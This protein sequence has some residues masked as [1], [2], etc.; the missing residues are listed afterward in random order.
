MG[1]MKIRIVVMFLFLC[2][3][4][5]N[6]QNYNY[7]YFAKTDIPILHLDKVEKYRDSTLL[8]CTYSADAGFW[9]NISSNTY[10]EDVQTKRKYKIRKCIGFPFSPDKRFFEN[11][12]AYPVIMYFPS[13][14]DTYQ[15]NVIDSSENNGINIYGIDLNNAPFPRSYNADEL[16][17]FIRQQEFY[18]QSGNIKKAI[19][20]SQLSLQAKKFIFGN[21]SSD[22]GKTLYILSSLQFQD[23]DIKKA[24]EYG[25]EGLKID[26]ENNA[27]DEILLD[28][29][30]NLS[31]YYKS[32]N[33]Y[34]KAI[35]LLV[36]SQ[37]IFSKGDTIKEEYGA[38]L[39]ELAHCNN[40]IGNYDKALNYAKQSLK[41]KKMVAGEDSESYA[42]ALS[43]Y[44]TAV[45]N[46]GNYDEAINR[47]I[48]C[49]KIFIAKIGESD[50]ANS[51]I[52]GNI[53]YNY[54]KKGN[55][56]K[57]LDYGEKACQ[58]FVLNRIENYDFVTFL[59]NMA[60]YYEK[61][62][63]SYKGKD[64][65]P[66]TSDYIRK[67]HQY[68][69][70]AL[71]VAKR[72]G[73]SM[74]NIYSER[75]SYFS[76]I[77]DFYCSIHNY[78]EAISLEKQSHEIRRNIFGTHNMLYG[79]SVSN[80]AWYYFLAGD[81]KNAVYYGEENIKLW[82]EL[83]GKNH[84]EYPAH[85]SDLAEYHRKNGSYQKAIDYMK[86]VADLYKTQYGEEVEHYGSSLMYLSNVYSYIGDF[87]N[88]VLTTEEIINVYRKNNIIDG[89]YI[90]FLSKLAAYYTIGN[91]KE[92]VLK[93]VDEIL[94]VSSRIDNK[95]GIEYAKLLSNI[96]TI[97]T[98]ID[99]KKAIEY[100]KKAADIFEKSK[101]INK[102]EYSFILSDVS[103]C[104][105]SA[106]DY[107]SAISYLEKR[108]SL[109][110][111]SDISYSLDLKE[112]AKNY[113][114]MKDYSKAVEYVS[115]SLQSLWNL[116]NLSSD[117]QDPYR[118]YLY[119][120]L[121]GR[122]EDLIEYAYKSNTNK[123]IALLY[124]EVLNI[125]T[126]RLRD[127]NANRLTWKDVKSHLR[128][129]EVAIEF[130][131]NNSLKDSVVYY[132]A[133]ILK[134]NQDYPSIIKLSDDREITKCMQ[135]AN[136][137]YE[138][139]YN[140]GKVI[141]G[142]LKKEIS[143]IKNI[144]FAPTFTLV[145]MPIEHFP[146][147][148]KQNYND[149]YN[150]Y[151]LSSTRELVV[152]NKDESFYS[153]AVLYGGLTYENSSYGTKSLSRSGFEPL[154]NTQIEINE[155]S[156]VLNNAGVK[157]TIFSGDNGTEESL[158]TLSGGNTDI[159]HIATHGIDDQSYYNESSEG[160][161]YSIIQK[162]EQY[163]QYN[164]ND[165]S[166]SNSFLAMSGAN[167]KNIE[168]L[169]DTANDGLL[170]AN[171]V[172]KLDFNNVQLLVL[173]ACESGRGNYGTDDMMWGI[174]RGFKEAGVKSILMSFK[175]VDDE[176]TRILMVEFYKNLMKGKTKLQ[177][178][179]DAQTYL[180]QV[181][182]G[183]YDNP[184]YWATFVLLDGLN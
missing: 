123:D 50:I 132:Y 38:I 49:L 95:E 125:R 21:R 157:S 121:T 103:L 127:G 9:A 152:G 26:K 65:N 52:C 176:A 60:N 90:S 101:E 184:D 159:L 172:S 97:Y 126:L 111:K 43:N 173:S 175:K 179:K 149:I 54:A 153:H 100:A 76:S 171:E 44:A 98:L 83:M 163:N 4:E 138:R 161:N 148:E 18:S 165:N 64:D 6:A 119:W 33:D 122:L 155:I 25:E 141:W 39:N 5:C 72:I 158:R 139:D 178:L 120:N 58:L 94:I 91:D 85:L 7:P 181:D 37:E 78:P 24:I 107:E 68:S 160:M 32:I 36:K 51:I 11:E 92:K 42:I 41:I 174:Q 129:N 67:I 34:P 66:N 69:D 45:S 63:S 88:F 74:D 142:R 16:I 117:G 31:T 80:L 70:S 113:A 105:S 151:R 144:Y 164:P 28:D 150:I 62:L 2:I 146:I 110:D 96:G 118:Q 82:T 133:L 156:K 99:S 12:G 86:E 56:E 79:K 104:Y 14:G 47:N 73:E 30:Y 48:E 57:A 115:L 1:N 8:Y 71:H 55:Y 81:Y 109:L 27:T 145:A 136:S 89:N 19:E 23:G 53:A 3:F 108:L 168:G 40:T 102:N 46:L 87:P 162:Y 147:N 177:S 128:D 140:I 180:R 112:I 20:F 167:K 154:Y 134:K 116:I 22:V 166:H 183:K 75:A 170:H 93:I 84:P 15:F 124:D 135:I 17:R 77:A 29:N 59:S 182:N 169:V 130:V 114:N 131:N 137:A 61:M 106:G 10:I 13:I 143:G 35:E